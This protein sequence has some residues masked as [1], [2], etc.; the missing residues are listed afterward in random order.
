MQKSK[1]T[2]IKFGDK[3]HRLTV[4]E[5][6][7]QDK[8]WRKFY[9]VKCDCGEFRTIM[10]SAMISGNTKSCG[11]FSKEVRAR[12]RVSK[13]HS[14]I[15]AIILGYQ[16]HALGRGFKWF[17][18]R[19]EVEEIIEKNCFYCD[20]PPSNVKKTKNSL[21]EGLL[22]SGIDRVDSTKDYTNQN[23]VPCCKIC[24]N[25]KSNMSLK[26]F[27]MWAEKIGQRAMASQWGKLL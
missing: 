14:E 25:A 11:C 6:S 12:R 13:N 16:R 5:F 26:C 4:L 23:C 1:N 9:K 24:N 8:R 17:L 3:F 18:S 15:T 21:E 10:G 7:H 27:K 19:K 2:E 20:S 22:Y